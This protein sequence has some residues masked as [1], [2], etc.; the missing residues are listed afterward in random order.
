M[1]HLLFLTMRRRDHLKR[2]FGAFLPSRPS[3]PASSP[4]IQQQPVV[5]PE[6]RPRPAL[7]IDT[8]ASPPDTAVSITDP[9]L[10]AAHKSLSVLAGAVAASSDDLPLA[11][12]KPTDSR[13][14]VID[15]L[16]VAFDVAEKL[17]GF[18]QTVPFIAP[19]AGLLSQIVKTYN[20]VKET[21]D[22]RNVLVLRV[23]AIA[24]DLYTTVRRLEDTK[25]IDLIKRLRPDIENYT[26]LLTEASKFVSDFDGLGRIHRGAARNQLGDTFSDFEQK[27]DFFGA[28]FRTNRLVDLAIQQNIAHETIEKV[29]DMATEERL[30][31]WLRSPPDMGQKQHD[32]QKLRKEGTG[33]WFLEGKLFIEWQDSPG[34]LWIQGSSGSGKTVLSSAVI[35]KLFD[36][37]QLFE[38]SGKSCAVAFF[39]FD[40]KSKV[41]QTVETA[42]RRLV[43]QLSA[44]SPYR[45]RAL[46]KHYNLSKGQALP[47]WHDLRSVLEEL[48]GEL[49]RYLYSS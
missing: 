26:E 21:H 27:F 48:L 15:N 42:L 43:L 39:Y 4:P 16:G 6:I 47:T 5:V 36:D 25:H 13:D 46:E 12:F 40:F 18:A 17:V 11:G 2:V 30:E 9:P 19:V 32:T 31:K 24:E 3:S 20:E 45:H 22:K 34:S 23:M 44:Q 1:P 8:G 7:R 29:Y 14:I 49:Q 35:R 38:N 10:A 33:S 41:G 28:R 37:Q